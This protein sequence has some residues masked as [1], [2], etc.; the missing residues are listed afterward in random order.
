MYLTGYTPSPLD[1]FGRPVAEIVKTSL[2][3]SA[4]V[5][6][7]QSADIVS[8]ITKLKSEGV[9][10]VAIEQAEGSVSLFDAVPPENVAYIFGNEITGITP[11]VLSLCDQIIEIPMAGQK[12][13][14]NVS[15]TAGIVL[16]QKPV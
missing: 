9:T 1:R 6:W 2:G 7:E 15:V 16:F 13:S 12:E 4:M 8:V 3:A 5:P 10:I 14:L 11:D